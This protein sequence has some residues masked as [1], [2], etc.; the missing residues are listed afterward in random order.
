MSAITA[1][2]RSA[3]G[4]DVSAV[5]ADPSQRLNIDRTPEGLSSMSSVQANGEA[6]ARATTG[7]ECASGFL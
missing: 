1:G 5:R 4:I 6:M 3:S 2:K 7:D